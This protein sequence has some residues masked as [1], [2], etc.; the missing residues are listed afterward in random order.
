MVESMLVEGT[1]VFWELAMGYKHLVPELFDKRVV[2]TVIKGLQVRD[3]N[4]TRAPLSTCRRRD[5][6]VTRARFGIVPC[7]RD[8]AAAR[9]R[10]CGTNATRARGCDAHETRAGV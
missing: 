8:E 5:V 2:K 3:T 10:E 6:I 1:H 7:R 4:V 9:T